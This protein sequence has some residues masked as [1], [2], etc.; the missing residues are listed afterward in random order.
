MEERQSRRRQ[1]RVRYEGTV[2]V[3]GVQ[4]ARPVLARA[5]NL[6][7]EGIAVTAEG[8]PRMGEE[9]ECRLVLGG[10]KTRLRG[11]VAWV[12]GEPEAERTR[13]SGG[14][15]Q[16]ISVAGE[17]RELLSKLVEDASDG[18]QPVDVWVAGSD[19]ALP[20]RALIGTE[21]VKLGM[22]LPRLTVG[23]S[24][25]IALVH[26]GVSERRQGTISAV[27]YLPGDGT[28]QSR[29]AMQVSTP[30]PSAGAGVI[31]AEGISGP[32]PSLYGEAELDEEREAS[33]VVDLAALTTS[34]HVVDERPETT[35]I[36]PYPEEEPPAPLIAPKRRLA[37]VWPLVALLGTVGG[38]AV[39]ALLLAPIVMRSAVKADPAT[40]APERAAPAPKPSVP[41][42]IEPLAPH[43]AA[44]PPIV[45]AVKPAPPRRHR[46]RRLHTTVD[47]GL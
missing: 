12:N 3:R 26:R 14:G 13:P 35:A 15:I 19:H 34:A 36:V 37:W 31:R 16:F 24:V 30:R 22:E 43:A 46:R 6:S 11:R 40:V 17:D 9:V 42:T 29:V 28:T 23:T 39:G 1:R 2:Y 41:M 45:P 44:A 5:Q 10:R 47:A 21:E 32:L 18:A 38:L 8:L 7:P 25:E 33:M 27:R 4:Q 20:M